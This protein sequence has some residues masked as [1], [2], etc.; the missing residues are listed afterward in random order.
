MTILRQ[1]CCSSPGAMFYWCSVSF[2]AWGVL[3]L[4]GIYWYP[5]HGSS[6][7]TICLAVGIGCVINWFRNRTLH[8]AITGPLFFIASGMFLL[9]DLHTVA[10]SLDYVWVGLAITTGVSFLLEWRHAM[11]TQR[12]DDSMKHGIRP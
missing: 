11:R 12:S 7:V 2:L 3:S 1:T 9:S 8:C 6:A 10:I 4:V 5:L